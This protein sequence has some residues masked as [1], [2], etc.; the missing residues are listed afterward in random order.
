MRYRRPVTDQAHKSWE[1]QLVVK[2]KIY[3]RWIGIG[4]HVPV[5]LVLVQ[6]HPGD[7]SI[8]AR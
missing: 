2:R 5:D 6:E 4:I 8:V 7:L 3:K 1:G